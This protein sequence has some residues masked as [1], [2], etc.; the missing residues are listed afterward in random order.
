MSWLYDLIGEEPLSNNYG[1]LGYSDYGCLGYS[2]YGCLG[3]SD[4]ECLGYS[5][6]L[7][8]F[9]RV[10]QEARYLWLTD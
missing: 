9:S 2:D 1:C 4:Y 7:N 3:Y 6:L 5:D 10:R 8:P